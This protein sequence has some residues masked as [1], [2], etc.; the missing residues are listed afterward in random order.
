MPTI[1]PAAVAAYDQLSRD[2]DPRIAG[3]V[4]SIARA[5]RAGLSVED[6]FSAAIS[7]LYGTYRSPEVLAAVA[8]LTIVRMAQERLAH[9]EAHDG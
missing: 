1:D 4:D 5:I 9:E 6:A 7:T 3:S 8:A 2:L